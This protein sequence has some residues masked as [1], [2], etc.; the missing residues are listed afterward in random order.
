MHIR[1]LFQHFAVSLD[2]PDYL[3]RQ[4][5]LHTLPAFELRRLPDPFDS[6][7]R[8]LAFAEGH[9]ENVLLRGALELPTTKKWGCNLNC[10]AED[11]KRGSLGE[12]VDVQEHPRYDAR[13]RLPLAVE[14][15]HRCEEMQERVLCGR[16]VDGGGLL[17]SRKTRRNGGW[18]SSRGSVGDACAGEG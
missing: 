10:L 11:G 9:G 7:P 2:D 18:A 8:P 6:R 5:L 17:C 3:S 14:H 1:L 15:D 13:G 4:P 16:D 12:R